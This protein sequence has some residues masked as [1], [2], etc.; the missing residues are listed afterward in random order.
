MLMLIWNNENMELDS[1]LFI[2]RRNESCCFFENECL[3]YPFVSFFKY[4]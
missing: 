1:V 4:K 3:L 2:M